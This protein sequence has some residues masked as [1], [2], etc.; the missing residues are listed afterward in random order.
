MSLWPPPRSTRHSAKRRKTI[1][2][3]A[4][5]GALIGL[6]AVGSVAWALRAGSGG[7]DTGG[8][9]PDSH[10]GTWSGDMSQEDD[11]GRHVTDWHVQIKLESGEERGSADYSMD[12]RGSLTLRE[13]EGDRLVFDYVETYDRDGRCIDESE[14]YLEPG[15]SADV[16]DARWEA[17]SHDGVP[18]TSTGTLR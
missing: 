8:S 11:E 18:M 6:A 10:A 14:L 1:I 3:A 13:R 12:C 2:V 7:P 4:L 15:S 9:V 17:V 5:V 16:L